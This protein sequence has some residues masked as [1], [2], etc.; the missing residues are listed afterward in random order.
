M[1]KSRTVTNLPFVGGHPVLDFVNT[2]DWRGSDDAV[3]DYLGSYQDLLAWAK[4]TGMF[5]PTHLA[6]SA[7]AAVVSAEEAQ[8]AL[9]DAKLLR[10]TIYDIATS[11]LAGRDPAPEALIMLNQMWRATAAGIDVSL[12]GMAGWMSQENRNILWAIEAPIVVQAVALLISPE[13]KMVRQ[14]ERQG[15]G[16]LFVDRSRRGIR[17]WCSMEDCGNAMKQ[18]RFRQKV[19]ALSS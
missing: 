19:G 18:S 5:T 10:E 8:M 4:R 12:L 14:C 11:L 3:I 9:D 17:R 2:C 15:C 13:L 7:R 1:R 16:W 6:E